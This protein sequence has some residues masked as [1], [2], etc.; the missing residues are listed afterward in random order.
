MIEDRDSCQF[1]AKKLAKT[2]WPKIMAQ[3]RVTIRVQKLPENLRVSS[4]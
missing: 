3:N 2:S 4:I 1:L